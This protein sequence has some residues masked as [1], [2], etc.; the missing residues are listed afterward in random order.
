M[1]IT[2]YE[3]WNMLNEVNNLVE[4]MLQR[5]ST[6]NSYVE[7]SHWIPAV[8]IKENPEQFILFADLPGV[9]KDKL[10]I[11]MENNILTIRGE[12]MEETK[13]VGENFSRIERIKGNF[14]R[15]FTLPD[16]AD[17]E[18]IQAK[19]KNGV[20]EIIIPKKEK[21]QPRRITVK[22]ED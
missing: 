17:S 11:A 14:Y 13:Q 2:R 18:R 22:A 4:N 20:L 3:P 16:T 10:E 6:D 12:R 7:T 5:R 21:A 19:T 1:S 15:R 9:D 8:D